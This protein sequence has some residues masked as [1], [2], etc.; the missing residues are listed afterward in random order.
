V[1]QPLPIPAILA[2]PRAAIMVVFAA[3]GCAVGALAG[4]IPTVTRAAGI[5]SFSLGLGI[6][7]SAIAS[8]L[9][10]ALGGTIA[11]RASNRALLLW[12]IPGF[13]LLLFAVLVSAGPA[14]FF[15]AYILLGVVMGLVDLFMN[16][17]GAAV[18]I[19]MGKPIFT[20]FH[21]TASGAMTVLALLAS[22]LSTEIGSWASGLAV[23]VS[24]AAAW[25]MVYGLVPARS[26]ARG[27]EARFSSIPSKL[28]LTLLGIT[29][30]LSIAAET[31]AILWSAKLLNE[32]APEL[33]AI[34]GAGAAFFGLCAASLRLVGDRL[35]A[36]FGD[37]PLMIGSILVAI[38][39]FVLLGQSQS[40]LLSVAAF[41]LV[42]FGTAV[43]VPCV[44]NL[45]ARIVPAN[46][47]AA[48]GFASLVAGLP[49]IVAPWLF[50][51][52]VAAAGISF[53]FGL[54]AMV[55][56]AALVLVVVLRN[57]R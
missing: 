38:V 40:F 35:R 36:R 54:Y 39:G 30:G 56:A 57:L 4:S 46:R 42:G 50:G 26:L 6:T 27:R 18:E 5:D 22:V 11:R 28:P 7:T 8:V 48:I 23:M 32:Q 41:A 1:P 13:G 12:G 9:T 45:A 34:A 29:A 33:A 24:M 14:S 19:D 2:S 47:A 3:F 43:L 17:E 16:A 10:M 15:I 21:G 20:A 44:F 53:A 37:L 31:T 25:L 51:W 49:R 55:M 52:V